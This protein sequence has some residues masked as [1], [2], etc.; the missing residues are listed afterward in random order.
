[1][2]KNDQRA[3][4][5]APAIHAA[6]EPDFQSANCGL[7]HRVSRRPIEPLT[8]AQGL[9]G[10]SRDQST[11]CR[12]HIRLPN[13]GGNISIHHEHEH[14]FARLHIDISKDRENV[15]AGDLAELFAQLIRP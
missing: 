1:M 13:D 8:S 15:S 12:H 3:L 14:P 4:A 7:L 10:S 9:A 6:G 11:V 2:K 5:T